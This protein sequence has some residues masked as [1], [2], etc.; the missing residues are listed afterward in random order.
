[1][2]RSAFLTNLGEGVDV[3]Q[4]MLKSISDK[5]SENPGQ[6]LRNV[7]RGLRSVPLGPEDQKKK[8]EGTDADK[9]RIPEQPP[10]APK[11]PL[12]G[13]VGGL[14]RGALD[15]ALAPP[16]EED[17]RKQKEDPDKKPDE[18]RQRGRALGGLIRGII[19][20]ATKEPEK[21]EETKRD[22]KPNEMP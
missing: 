19:D 13:R 8:D 11:G 18:A 16:K 1:V 9:G 14:I 22:K 2:D 15:E 3:I 6:P 20:E 21:K 5:S 12:R 4:K 7:I 17:E 10:A